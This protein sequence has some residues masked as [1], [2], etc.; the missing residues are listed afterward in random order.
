MKKLNVFRDDFP[1]GG[2]D[3]DI[4]TERT[5]YATMNTGWE[6]KIAPNCRSVER[7]DGIRFHRSDAKG[8]SAA[9]GGECRTQLWF[10]KHMP[11]PLLVIRANGGR[12]LKAIRQKYNRDPNGGLAVG[13]R[14]RGLYYEYTPDRRQLG[15]AFFGQPMVMA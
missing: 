1:G 13:P 5:E 10:E 7:R 3:D 15:D 4:A 9:G 6:T 11:L 14:R 12:R 8:Q 2:V